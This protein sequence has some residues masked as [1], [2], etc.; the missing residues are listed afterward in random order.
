[1][2]RRERVDELAAAGLVWLAVCGGAADR[3]VAPGPDGRLPMARP[4]ADL[5]GW[6]RSATLERLA[7]FVESFADEGLR[8]WVEKQVGFR[9]Y[10]RA[11]YAPRR[12]MPNGMRTK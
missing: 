7:E 8:D 11:L 5:W 6:T 10:S 9:A 2:P 4:V 12:P 3:K 1:M